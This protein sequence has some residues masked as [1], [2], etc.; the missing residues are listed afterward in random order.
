MSLVSG[1]G[2]I[3]E[4]KDKVWPSTE[5]VSLK[6]DGSYSVEMDLYENDALRE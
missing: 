4:T 3:K 6:E 5:N 2:L 1:D